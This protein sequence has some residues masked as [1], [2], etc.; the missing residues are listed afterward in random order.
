MSPRGFHWV[1]LAIPAGLFAGILSL[2]AGFGMAVSSD[3]WPDPWTG[4]SPFLIEAEDFNHAAGQHEER[5]SQMPYYGGAYGGL[6]AVAGRD[7]FREPVEGDPDLYRTGELPGVP[8]W[9]RD[10]GAQGWRGSEAW[11]VFPNFSLGWSASG[12]WFNYTRR[13]PPGLYHVWASV[14]SEDDREGGIQARL[15]QVL[16]DP[17]LP[18]QVVET[19]GVFE[20]AGSGGWHTNRLV[21]LR[22]PESSEPMILMVTRFP[23]PVTLRFAPTLG[24]ADY[25]VLNRVGFVDDFFQIGARR[26]PTGSVVIERLGTAEPL[27][28]LE[29]AADLQG[30]STVWNDLGIRDLP[31]AVPMD[32]PYRYFRARF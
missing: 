20:A 11:T 29:G 12:Q 1:R 3:P 31:Y 5:A 15:E 17:R 14:A 24:D 4:I 2:T 8:L 32:S 9:S 21:R 16:T 27:R 10:E 7:Y 28:S 23:S 13:I 25:L 6:S 26:T 19:L 30:E 22:R 18:N